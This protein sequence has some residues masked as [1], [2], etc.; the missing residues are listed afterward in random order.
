[1]LV[2]LQQRSQTHKH[3]RWSFFAEIGNGLKPLTIS[4]KS[5]ILDVWVGLA[6]PLLWS[7]PRT[8]VSLYKKYVYCFNSQWATVDTVA[9]INRQLFLSI[10]FGKCV[11]FIPLTI[12][13]SKQ[14]RGDLRFQ[15]FLA[16]VG[17]GFTTRQFFGALLLNSLLFWQKNLKTPL[18]P[19]GNVL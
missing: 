8:G 5:S 13:G 15:A 1:M 12:K 11:N 9:D 2:S 14:V 7:P 16:I 3:L 4:A 6:T 19:L 10:S 18:N 17:D